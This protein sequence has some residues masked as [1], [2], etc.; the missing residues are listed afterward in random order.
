MSLA[1]RVGAAAILVST[2]L[3]TQGRGNLEALVYQKQEQ[4]Q[5]QGIYDTD[6]IRFLNR[7]NTTKTDKDILEQLVTLSYTNIPSCLRY[8]Y[9]GKAVKK[10]RQFV[11]ATIEKKFE[12]GKNDDDKVKSLEYW[13]LLQE[14]SSFHR[15]TQSFNSSNPTIAADALCAFR[16]IVDKYKGKK[17]KELI[18]LHKKEILETFITEPYKLLMNTRGVSLK[19]EFYLAYGTSMAR[20]IGLNQ[21]IKNFIK[22]EEKGMRSLNGKEKERKQ[23]VHNLIKGIM[24][25]KFKVEP[26]YDGKGL[27]RV[28]AY[29]VKRLKKVKNKDGV[30]KSLKVEKENIMKREREWRKEEL[31]NFCNTGKDTLVASLGLM[32]DKVGFMQEMTGY[33]N[34]HGFGKNHKIS[35]I[36]EVLNEEHIVHEVSHSTYRT[37]MRGNSPV[38]SEY[39]AFKEEQNNKDSPKTINEELNDED[40]PKTPKTLREKLNDEAFAKAKKIIEEIRR[41]AIRKDIVEEKSWN[42]IRS[43]RDYR[44][45]YMF[46]KN[47]KFLKKG[48]L[49]QPKKK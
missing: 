3:P 38:L 12:E 7:I 32:I 9:L 33:E 31:R 23:Q 44:S 20:F 11:L 46:T 26:P 24:E 5:T 30:F 18:N 48:K 42:V 47:G 21:D 28:R 37:V 4:A 27:E 17:R 2:M 15:I 22:K 13:G 43:V 40:S 41:K 8:F 39:V 19:G 49:I 36:D 10:D 29:M 16:N 35:F 25:E 6:P 34:L 14:E 45:L 1:S